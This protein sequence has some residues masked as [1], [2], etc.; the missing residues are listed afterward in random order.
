MKGLLKFIFIYAIMGPITITI[1]C[2][3]WIFNKQD[4]RTNYRPYYEE[5]DLYQKLRRDQNEY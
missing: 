1:Y 4:I 5:G 3:K 2:I